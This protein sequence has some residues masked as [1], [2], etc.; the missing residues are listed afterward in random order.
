MEIMVSGDAYAGILIIWPSK[1]FYAENLKLLGSSQVLALTFY[2]TY[3]YDY[4]KMYNIKAGY[5]LNGQSDIDQNNRLVSE[6]I[7][8]IIWRGKEEDL[9]GFMLA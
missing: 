2:L 3:N 5:A 9:R 8:R 6:I 1:G 4:N 7:R